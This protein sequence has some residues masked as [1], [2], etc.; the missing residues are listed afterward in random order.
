MKNFRF[1]TIAKC[2][3]YTGT[4]ITTEIQMRLFIGTSAVIKY[5]QVLKLYKY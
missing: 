4:L 3:H 5:H 2:K 1:E